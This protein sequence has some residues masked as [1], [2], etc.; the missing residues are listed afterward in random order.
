MDDDTLIVEEANLG[1]DECAEQN[2]G[3]SELCMDTF[4]SY[5][6]SC[7]PGRKVDNGPFYCEQKKKEPVCKLK[8]D[9]VFVIDAA[10]ENAEGW[11]TLLFFLKDLIKELDVH[12]EG[13]HVGVVKYDVTATVE[14]T[15]D[16][17]FDDLMIEEALFRIS[18]NPEG[19]NLAAGLQTMREVVF[20][21]AGGDR[22]DVPNIAILLTM[23]EPSE[24]AQVLEQAQA[25]ADS[26]I[27]VLA[28]GVGEDVR[29]DLLMHLPDQ[30][31]HVPDHFELHSLVQSL[32]QAVINKKASICETPTVVDGI[33]CA[34]VPTA[35]K[36]CFCRHHGAL[37][38][39][40]GSTCTNVDECLYENGGCQHYC[41]D[42][43]GSFQCSCREGYFLAP[44]S[45]SCERAV[46]AER[47][48]QG[49]DLAETMSLTALILSAVNGVFF[50]GM[51][52]YC[53]TKCR[54][55]TG[56]SAGGYLRHMY[57]SGTLNRGLSIDE[58]QLRDCDSISGH[59]N[60]SNGSN[61]RM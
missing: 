1:V 49:E 43:D 32:S 3:C 34:N 20:T 18:Q 44:D 23:Q 6:C 25:A 58:K 53:C 8:A 45:R 50:I 59:S 7:R 24:P 47:L 21:E 22:K 28:V 4:D 61:T 10:G 57:S 14:F 51:L 11:R 41:V 54:S 55:S 13:V 2:G 35:G 26:D 29:K 39:V 33:Y 12:M 27:T 31:F 56:S 5:F 17:Y 40:N 19:G 37:T 30:A 38:P 36:Y 60:I 16:R 15:L 42:T 46:E 52:V 9:V 48:V